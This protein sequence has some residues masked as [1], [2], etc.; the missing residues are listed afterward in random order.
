MLASDVKTAS[1]VKIGRLKAHVVP[2]GAMNPSHELKSGT[3][4]HELDI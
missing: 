1:G 3:L 2:L 4:D